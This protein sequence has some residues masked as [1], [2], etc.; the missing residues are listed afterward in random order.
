[1]VKY[2]LK[3]LLLMNYTLLLMKEMIYNLQVET[4]EQVVG[5]WTCHRPGIT[6]VLCGAKRAYQIEET[7]ASMGWQLSDDQLARI[8][9][10]MKERGTPVT[11]S[12]V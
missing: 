1:M 8:E 12:A 2:G 10:A 4:V 9:Q 7:A 11:R 3:I 6:S 5:N